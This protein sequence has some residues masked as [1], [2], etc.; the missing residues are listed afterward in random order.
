MTTTYER[1]DSGLIAPVQ[2]KATPPE[3]EVRVV[4]RLALALLG[5][6]LSDFEQTTHGCLGPF[7]MA[8]ICDRLEECYREPSAF[9]ISSL[10]QHIRGFLMEDER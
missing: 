7:S 6:H 10:S 3:H 9:T 2:P 5:R 1:R 8:S 4:I